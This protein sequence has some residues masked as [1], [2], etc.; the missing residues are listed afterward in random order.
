MS[1]CLSLSLSVYIGS[2]SELNGFLL[3]FLSLPSYSSNLYQ[4]EFFFALTNSHNCSSN[5]ILILSRIL[6]IP[7]RLKTTP[8]KEFSWKKHSKMFVPSYI[9][10]LFW[11]QILSYRFRWTGTSCLTTDPFNDHI[12]T[13]Q[14]MSA[15]HSP[16]MPRHCLWL[17]IKLI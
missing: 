9:F 14:A 17:S 4:L 16:V 8:M 5:Y 12:T 6:T 13:P 7:Q 2:K 1:V 15:T 3:Y 11:K 10:A